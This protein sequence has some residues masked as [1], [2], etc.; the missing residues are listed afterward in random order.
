MKLLP[1][2]V[3]IILIAFILTGCGSTAQPTTIPDIVASTL[4][5]DFTP[6]PTATNPKDRESINYNYEDALSTR[7]LLGFGTL[8]LAETSTPVNVEQAPQMLML[9]QALDNLTNS[10][11]SAE[12]E[13]NALLSQVEMTFSSEQIATINAMKLTQLD[14]QTWVQANGITIGSGTGSEQGAGQG[15]GQG[16]GMSPEAKA[17]K[18][19]ENGGAG[20]SS[21]NDNGLS[22]VL[23]R[24]LITYLE[25]IN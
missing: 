6:A 7:L 8:K 24:T 18:Q 4:E 3:T 10:G 25:N 17:T 13:V 9:W 20:N 1:F 19:A 11:T 21:E 14:L 12:A 22:S 16:G 23:T 5:V 2:I 15:M